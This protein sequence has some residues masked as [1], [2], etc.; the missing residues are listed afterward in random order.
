MFGVGHLL[1][2]SQQE[3]PHFLARCILSLVA[4]CH[5]STD[6]LPSC[7]L[8]S[9]YPA[10]NHCSLSLF[11]VHAFASLRSLKMALDY[12][13]IELRRDCDVFLSRFQFA[14]A[15]ISWRRWVRT[16]ICIVHHLRYQGNKTSSA[17][18]ST[19][20][21]SSGRQSTLVVQQMSS[22]L[23]KSTQIL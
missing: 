13:G 18:V 21:T 11:D 6:S 9:S 19:R 12:A 22:L 14:A 7:H 16:V 2:Q 17:T 5:L 8:A 3:A 10:A 20:C 23:F 15:S 4:W 1:Q